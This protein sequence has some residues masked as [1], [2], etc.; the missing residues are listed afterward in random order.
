MEWGGRDTAGRRWVGAPYQSADRST[1]AVQGVWA[2][3]DEEVEWIWT[4]GPG[5]SYVSGWTVTKRPLPERFETTEP[6][7]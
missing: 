2:Y 3:D 1:S 4:H 6:E 7:T 5:G